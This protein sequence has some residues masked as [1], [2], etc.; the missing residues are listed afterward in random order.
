MVKVRHTMVVF[1]IC[2]ILLAIS[3]IHADASQH[4]PFYCFAEDPIRPQFGMFSWLTHYD[5][6]RGQ[7]IDP[8]VSSCTPSKFWMLSRHGTRFPSGVEMESMVRYS[9]T[10]QEDILKNYE[11]G[12]TSLCTNDLELIRNWEFDLNITNYE[13]QLTTSG[14]KELEGIG[15]RYQA[16]FPTLLPPTYFESH[17]LFKSSDS[18]R[19]IASNRGLA[20]GF[21]GQNGFEQVRLGLKS[22]T[23]LICY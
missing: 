12:K 8:T 20:D 1:T 10:L 13:M 19:T 23:I 4:N 7:H 15:Q 3:S 11:A 6:N 14:W 18:Q 22:Q 21:F 2:L 17:Y 5:R 9:K 16:A